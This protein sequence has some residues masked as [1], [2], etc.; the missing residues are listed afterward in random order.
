VL[1]SSVSSTPLR[2]AHVTKLFVAIVAIAILAGLATYLAIPKIRTLLN[3]EV[4][5]T[6][7]EG[8]TA[9]EIDAILAGA[10]VTPAGSV[11]AIAERDE[12]EGYLFPDTY[13]FHPD[14][15][16]EAVV[17]RL[18]A[19]WEEKAAPILDGQPG[20][21]RDHVIVASILEREVPDP[22]DQRVVAG[23]IEKRLEAGMPLQVDAAIC[24]IKALE[25]P[26][27]PCYPIFA[28]D[29]TNASPYNTYLYRGLPP[30]PIG[31]PG[32]SALSASIDAQ[33]SPY[34]FYL[35]DP[36]TSRT[37]F[38]ATNEEHERNKDRYLR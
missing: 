21:V 6:I 30:G 18:V 8:V 17:A 35:S 15:D 11:A 26:G 34:W 32:A 22:A 4:T 20:D 9:R 2:T 7:P 29:L 13:R 27:T 24:Y 28:V 36:A 37:I 31:N 14:S 25:S 19:T 10:G 1:H 16:P 33:A 38:S 5:V 12:R 23:I 3:P